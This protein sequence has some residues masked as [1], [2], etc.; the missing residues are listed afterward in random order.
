MFTGII[1]ELGIVRSLSKKGNYTVLEIRADKIMD[2]VKIGDSIA[3]N[4]ACLTVVKEEKDYLSF[5]VMEETLR[6][7]NLCELHPNDLVNLERA[8]KAGDRLS[9]HFV[10]GHIDAKGLIRKKSFIGQNLC[11]EIATPKGLG[12]YIALKGSVAVDGISL[13]VAALT[14]TTFSVYIIPHTLKNTTFK[15]KNAGSS[16]NIEVD[17]LAKYIL[18]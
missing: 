1:E 4:G 2:D 3:V 18:K 6:L 8:L 5:E 17:M 15:Y 11:F 12:K 10:A 13:T 16:V 7:T 14:A 9:G